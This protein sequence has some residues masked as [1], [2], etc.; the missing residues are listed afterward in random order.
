MMAKMT[1][2]M[3]IPRVVRRI[4]GLLTRYKK[5]RYQLKLLI[6]NNINAFI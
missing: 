6:Y 5:Q 1:Y 4:C 3:V 2:T